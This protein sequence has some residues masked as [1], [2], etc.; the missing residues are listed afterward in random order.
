M[1]RTNELLD[2]F[3]STPNFLNAEILV[4]HIDR[5]PQVL[6]LLTEDQEGS[7]RNAIR[8]VEPI[9]TRL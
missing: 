6:C 9:E 8:M 5:R 3:N 2:R 1:N 4:R 7:I